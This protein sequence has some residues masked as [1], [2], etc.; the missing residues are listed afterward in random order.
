MASKLFN[1]G[2]HLSQVFNQTGAYLP[3]QL[4]DTDFRFVETFGTDPANM[5]EYGEV[6]KLK[7]G[8]PTIV[9]PLEAADTASDIYGIVVRT[10]NQI[11][12]ATYGIN[13]SQFVYETGAG[14]QVSVMR[15]GIIAV[16]VQYGTPAI[17]TTLLVRIG[18]NSTYTHLP[19]GGVE[20]GT[21]VDDETITVTGLRFRSGPAF[22]M[23]STA[24]INVGNG[25]GQTA[26]VA[27]DF[28]L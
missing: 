1:Y 13:G 3:G 9:V 4:A 2:S 7:S 20:A 8:S 10:F 11:S 15:K 21:A 16:P 18:A 17:G 12:G 27:I 22:P 5:V 24:V 6:V 14:G 26:K 25:V 23:Q 19:I 28:T